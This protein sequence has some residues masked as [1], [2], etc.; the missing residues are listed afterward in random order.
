MTSMTLQ[1]ENLSTDTSDCLKH[2]SL[3]KSFKLSHAF[4]LV[5][6]LLCV[7]ALCNSYCMVCPPVRGDNQLA[8]GLSAEQADKPWLTILYH[9]NQS[10]PCSLKLVDCLPVQ[11]AKPWYNYSVP[12]L[13]V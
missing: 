8:N 4:S 6:Y 12:P 10:R 9:P 3:L 11:A 7:P 5:L 2:I 13:S 1:A